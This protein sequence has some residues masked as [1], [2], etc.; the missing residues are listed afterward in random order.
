MSRFFFFFS[1]FFSRI[2]DQMDSSLTGAVFMHFD[3]ENGVVCRNSEQ[4]DGGN[5]DDYEIRVCCR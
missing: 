1:F 5:C 4:P 3:L 2:S